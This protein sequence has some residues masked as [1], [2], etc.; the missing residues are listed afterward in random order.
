MCIPKVKSKTR[1]CDVCRG[2]GK[3]LCVLCRGKGYYL[4]YSD[5]YKE[6]HCVP[7]NGTGT[8]NIRCAKC[9]GYGVIKQ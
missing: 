2:R 3:L 5:H 4:D 7:C 8:R 6:Y 9:K 1:I